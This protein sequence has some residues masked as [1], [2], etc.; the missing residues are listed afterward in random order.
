MAG[1]RRP[2]TA[3]GPG[4]CVCTK[5]ARVSVSQ[6]TCTYQSMHILTPAS[7]RQRSVAMHQTSIWTSAIGVEKHE[8]TNSVIEA[9][10]NAPGMGTGKRGDARR[11]AAAAAIQATGSAARALLHAQACCEQPGW[12]DAQAGQAHEAHTVARVSCD[13]AAHAPEHCLQTASAAAA[14][15]ATRG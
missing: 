14:S 7:L 13:A 3:C 9:T 2:P 4:V 1:S 12:R 6:T 5:R 11:A 8:N 10:L 15:T